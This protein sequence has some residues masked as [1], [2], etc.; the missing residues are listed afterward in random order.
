MS[1]PFTAATLLLLLLL[2]LSS[3]VDQALAF[4]AKARSCAIF[5][6]REAAGLLLL[7]LLLSPVPQAALLESK[8]A[9]AN[10]STVSTPSVLAKLL[11]LLHFLLHVLLLFLLL[12]LLQLMLFLL[13]L[14]LL[15]LPATSHVAWA[16]PP[17]SCTLPAT[18]L[19][20]MHCC[21]HHGG[22]TCCRA[23]TPSWTSCN[24]PCRDAT[25]LATSLRWQADGADGW[26]CFCS[27]CSSASS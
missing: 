16:T 23:D 10:R 12:V 1:D 14:L 20:S 15:L 8:P 21:S 24:I 25:V 4:L 26:A 9:D 6:L 2:P 11:I 7:L 17:A 3:L 18:L 13:L 5:D 22:Y 19:L 27:C